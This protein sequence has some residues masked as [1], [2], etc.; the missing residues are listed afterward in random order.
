MA[1]KYYWTG[2]FVLSALVHLSLYHRSVPRTHLLTLS[3]R[4]LS[5]SPSNVSEWPKMLS[6]LAYFKAFA[7][8]ES[9]PQ[10][11]IR[12]FGISFL[13]KSRGQQTRPLDHVL[14]A[15]PRNPWTKTML[16]ISVYIIDIGGIEL[17]LQLFRLLLRGEHRLPAEPCQMTLLL[18]LHLGQIWIS[19]KISLEISSLVI[20]VGM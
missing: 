5:I 3:R 12:A 10:V 4:S 16:L 6:L 9:Y 18:S 14:M 11:I 13:R 20:A 15:Y 7:T 19:S 17:T 1:N 2:R 8:L